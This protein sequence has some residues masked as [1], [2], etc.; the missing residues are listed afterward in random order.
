MLREN[1]KKHKPGILCLSK[2][3]FTS[4]GEIVSD[5]KNQGNLREALALL[6]YCIISH[7][8]GSGLMLFESGFGLAENVCYKL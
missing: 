1:K 4:E 5:K 6:C 8:Q 3:S 2:L 7:W